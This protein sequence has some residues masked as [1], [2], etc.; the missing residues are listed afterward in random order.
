LKK[1]GFSRKLSVLNIASYDIRN[2]A[3]SMNMQRILLKRVFLSSV[4][5]ASTG[6]LFSAFAQSPAA[7]IVYKHTDENGR[8]TYSNSPRKGAVVVDLPTL[9]VMSGVA[10]RTPQ[11]AQPKPANI[12]NSEA[13]A[14]VAEQRES[15]SPSPSATAQI[16]A[17][18]PAAPAAQALPK[19]VTTATKQTPAIAS[20]SA[21]SMAQQ[22]REDVRRRILEGE[23][24]AEDQ[25]LKEARD[26]L[27][28]EQARSPAMRSLR[29][30]LPNEARPSETTKESRALVERHFGRVRDLQDQ[31]VMHEQNLS[32]L[33]EMLANVASAA[34]QLKPRT[35]S[36][37]PSPPTLQAPQVQPKVAVVTTTPKR[38]ASVTSKTS[39]ASIAKPNSEP[40][41]ERDETSMTATSLPIVKLKPPAAASVAA[42][43]TTGATT[44]VASVGKRS[45]AEDR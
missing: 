17:T 39:K 7:P 1:L 12:A 24:E 19:P 28:A 2:P 31:L 43:I 38:P 45:M 32:E 37:L 36:A 11:T 33:R 26:M 21:A 8:I 20:I 41:S 44:N 5:F 22:R 35:P 30:S 40:S 42:A 23:I 18:A 10:S 14:T 15:P 25:L 6:F 27:N 34:P 9:T 4:I 13:P 16:A 29:A 3:I